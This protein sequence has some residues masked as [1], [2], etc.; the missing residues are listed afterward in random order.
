MPNEF[1]SN[2]KLFADD[3]SLFAVANDKNVCANILNNDLLAISKRAFNWKMLFNPDPKKPAQEV[4]FSRK[5]QVQ[6]HPTINLNNVEVERVPF[7]KHLGFM[8]DEK[9]NFRQH[10]DSAISKINTGIAVI[11]KLRYTLP[12]NSLIYDQPQKESFCE[13]IESV[14]YKAALAI[15]GAIQ[16]TSREKIYHELGL[17]SLKSR[18]WYKRLTSMFK[19]MRN[20]APDYLINLIPK[21]EHKIK[22]RNCQI[23]TYHCRTD[24]FKYSFFPSALSEWFKLDESI[25]NSESIPIFKN[26]LLSFIRPAQSSI[27]NI[28]DPVG[29]KCLTRFR[30]DFSHLNEHRFRHNFKNCL[31]PLCSCSLEIE[32]TLHYLLHCRHF[33][34]HRRDLMNSVKSVFNNFESLPDNAKK[35]VLLYGDSLLDHNQS[36]IIIQATINYIKVSERFSELNS[37][38]E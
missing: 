2:A 37:L 38:F 6:I 32:D 29:I 33:S 19:I 11:K 16:G 17:E 8:L 1:Q 26:K 34:V 18:R 10:I 7:Q 15:T 14:Q 3:T 25:R 27:F 23:S 31:N 24:C 28:F 4:L 30:L 21:R 9:L 5:K 35:D 13:K 36:K 20:E 22:T 12:R